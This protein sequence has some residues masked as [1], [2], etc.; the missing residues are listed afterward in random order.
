M[1]SFV[2]AIRDQVQYSL[3]YAQGRS[4]AFPRNI[5]DV[6]GTVVAK[7][8]NLV[9]LPLPLLSFLALPLYGRYSSNFMMRLT[10]M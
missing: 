4:F 9:T 2:Q 7:A 10:R 6:Y 3:G 5:A 1:A 8:T